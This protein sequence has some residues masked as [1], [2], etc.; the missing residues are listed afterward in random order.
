MDQERALYVESCVALGVFAAF[1]LVGVVALALHLCWHSCRV[2]ERSNFAYALVIAFGAMRAAKELMHVTRT[3]HTVSFNVT[4][5]LWVWSL[6]VLATV[7]SMVRAVCG[8]C[9]CVYW[10]G[11]GW[12]RWCEWL[13]FFSQ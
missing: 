7:H 5:A 9:V 8:V 4:N 1:V 3:Y 11:E 13:R 10:L 6:A 12:W 2:L